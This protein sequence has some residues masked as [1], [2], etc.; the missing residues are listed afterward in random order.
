M[1][2]IEKRIKV[3]KSKIEQKRAEKI[4]AE[5]QIKEV[6]EIL[7]EKGIKPEELDSIINKKQDEIKEIKSKLIKKLEEAEN[8]FN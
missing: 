5:N 2:D 1:S 3:L 6:N 4:A 7:K 8:V